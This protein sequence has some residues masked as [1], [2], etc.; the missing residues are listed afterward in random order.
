MYVRDGRDYAC[1]HNKYIIIGEKE[2]K[3]GRSM[4]QNFTL[5]DFDLVLTFHTPLATY[6]SLYMYPILS[7][8]GSIPRVCSKIYIHAE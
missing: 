2:T 5:V 4:I 7:L 8:S 3:R 6:N 1:L